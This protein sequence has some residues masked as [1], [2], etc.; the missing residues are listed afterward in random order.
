MDKLLL[1]DDEDVYTVSLLG[2]QRLRGTVRVLWIGAIPF[3]EVTSAEPQDAGKVHGPFGH[4]AIF[5][6]APMTDAEREQLRHDVE[7]HEGQAQR[8]AERKAVEAARMAKVLEDAPKFSHMR[9][10]LGQTMCGVPVDG[11]RLEETL[12]LAD[13]PHCAVVADDIPY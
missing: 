1:I 2:R 8:D 6:L 10:G 4:G 12:N 13:C 7:W 11:M 9:T 5:S 3:F